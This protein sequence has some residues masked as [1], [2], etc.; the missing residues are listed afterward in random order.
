MTDTD[1][2]AKRWTVKGWDDDHIEFE[3]DG[4]KWVAWNDYCALDAE[5]GPTLADAYRAGL[6]A[7]A[8][9]CDERAKHAA[10]RGLGNFSAYEHD[11]RQIRA[12]K[13]PTEFGG[14]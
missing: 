11:A 8:K 6:E 5:P 10:D 4:G 9:G 12:M 2:N 13:V 14:E 7:A 3:D 1:K